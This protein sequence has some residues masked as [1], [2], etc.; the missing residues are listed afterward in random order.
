MVSWQKRNAQQY[1]TTFAARFISLPSSRQPSEPISSSQQRDAAPAEMGALPMGSFPRLS[2]SEVTLGRGCS[3]Q[4][5]GRPNK[6]S[7]SWQG[8]RT[9]E[10]PSAQVTHPTPMA[11]SY[12]SSPF[13]A[14]AFPGT[15]PLAGAG[16]GSAK[17]VSAGRPCK[18]NMQLAGFLLIRRF[19]WLRMELTLSSA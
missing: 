4:L 7:I 2:C 9:W 16:P 6:E 15:P 13:P 1:R 18:V 11:K 17:H 5:S 8:R 14:A 19:F 3:I 10:A 12:K